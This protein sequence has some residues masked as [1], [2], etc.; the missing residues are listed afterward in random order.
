MADTH[1]RQINNN[2]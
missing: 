2:S 1:S